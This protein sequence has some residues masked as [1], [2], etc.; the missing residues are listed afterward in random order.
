MGT[1]TELGWVLGQSWGGYS[2]GQVQTADVNTTTP[3]SEL[4][5]VQ[6]RTELGWVPPRTEL[7]WVRSGIV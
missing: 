6:P 7:G 5:W 4:G 3:R 2:L 1:R